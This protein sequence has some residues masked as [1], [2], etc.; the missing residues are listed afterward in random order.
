MD[1]G[2]HRDIHLA[3]L[4]GTYALSLFSLIQP[5]IFLPPSLVLSKPIAL[6][7]ALSYREITSSSQPLFDVFSFQIER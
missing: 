2:H 7:L 4:H 1:R 3:N 5:S 6:I